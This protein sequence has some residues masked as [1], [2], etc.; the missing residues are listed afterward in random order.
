[1]SRKIAVVSIHNLALMHGVSLYIIKTTLCKDL[2]L[3]KKSARWGVPKL[4]TKEQK[5]ERVRISQKFLDLEGGRKRRPWR[6]H[7]NE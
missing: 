7:N 6:D 2:G 1:V 4:L 3:A 5:Q